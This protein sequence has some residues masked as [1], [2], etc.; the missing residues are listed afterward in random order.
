[1]AALTLFAGPCAGAEAEGP[2]V[3]QRTNVS[4]LLPQVVGELSVTLTLYVPG[5]VGVRSAELFATSTLFFFQ[6]Y[7]KG[8][9]PPVTVACKCAVPRQASTKLIAT[10]GLGLI[11]MVIVSLAGPHDPAG[12]L[13]VNVS[14]T[15]PAAISAAEGV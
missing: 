6:W 2:S 15:D 11:V 14:V 5:P 4:V 9:V 3:K 7:V 13:V 8:P 1:M 12:S 10:D